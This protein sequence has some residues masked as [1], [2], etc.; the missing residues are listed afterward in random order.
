MLSRYIPKLRIRFGKPAEMTDTAVKSSEMRYGRIHF[1][2]SAT[3][4][5][6][7]AGD[8]IYRSVIFIRTSGMHPLSC[9][10]GIPAGR[11]Y[12][13][14]QTGLCRRPH[15]PNRF[16]PD[17]SVTGVFRNTEFRGIRII[18]IARHRAFTDISE[19]QDQFRQ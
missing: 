17:I 12:R 2:V 18:L 6:G 5:F 16:F 10:T 13:M 19:S 3:V 8:F 4:F 9:L 7:R 11:N 14:P 1:V 15:S